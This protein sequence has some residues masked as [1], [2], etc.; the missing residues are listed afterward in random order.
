MYKLEPQGDIGWALLDGDNLVI[1]ALAGA[2]SGELLGPVR[3]GDFAYLYHIVSK[4]EGRQMTWAEAATSAPARVFSHCREQAN[5]N[6]RDDM[7]RKYGVKIDE[8]AVRSLF[9]SVDSR[10]R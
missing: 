8:K 5:Q 6:L 4:R 9:S 10:K 1:R 2:K 7:F 3:E